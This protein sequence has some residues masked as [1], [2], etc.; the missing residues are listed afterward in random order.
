MPDERCIDTQSTLKGDLIYGSVSQQKN[1]RPLVLRP[2]RADDV[3]SVREAIDESLDQVQKWLPWG[4]EEP[5]SLEHLAARLGKYAAECARGTAWRLALVDAE[6][7][8]FIGSGSLLPF[9]GPN[10]LEVGY[11]VRRGESGRGLATRVAGALTRY[12]F[13]ERGVEHVE[14]WMKPG[15][16]V[17]AAVARRLGFQFR[18]QKETSRAGAAPQAYDIF[19]LQSLDELRSPEDP[20]VRIEVA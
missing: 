14:L 17:S 3:M 1:N 12:A 6:T 16:T 19:I 13:R 10:A 2:Y 7:N 8:R 9:V 18:E 5:S 20:Y 11:W 15:H 4:A